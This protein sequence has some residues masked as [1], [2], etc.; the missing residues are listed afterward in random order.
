MGPI[1]IHY[2]HDPRI[3][4]A[5]EMHSAWGTFEWVL[6]DGFRMRRRVGV[7]CN[8]DGHKGRPGASYPGASRFGAYGGLTCFLTDRNDRGSIMEA[9]RR[10]HHYGTTG[11]RMHL[12]VSARFESDAALFRRNPLSSP[13]VVPDNVRNAMMGDIVR[14]T[15]ETVDIDIRVEA[16]AGIL[17]VELR[18]AD[19]VIER[20]QTD[21][22]DDLGERIRVTW[23][24]AEY[25][26]R[27]RDV[28]W[29]GRAQF[30]QARIR[31]LT[32]INTWN[33]ETILDQRGSQSVVWNG[34]TTGNFMGF[35]AYLA[36]SRTGRLN[37][38]TN[39]R[40]LDV[41]LKEVGFAPSVFDAGGLGKKITIQRLPDAPLERSVIATRSVKISET[42]DTPVW[43]RVTTEDGF[44]A[45]S[46]PIYLYRK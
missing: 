39:Q 12:A 32:T 40:M 7:V 22:P 35:D 38:S 21:S 9:Q 45:W 29:T 14:V 28:R 6:T 3:E 46:S 30:D 4:T 43:V 10:R 36:D 26:G 27:G 44:Q 1:N 19:E 20:L 42:G 23:S 37:I 11:C 15:D 16:H 17:E 33:P 5:V 2:D 18:D 25:R 8:S 41:A 31:D 34:V 13:D 24:G